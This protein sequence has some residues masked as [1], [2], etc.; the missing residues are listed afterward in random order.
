MSLTF[1]CQ[2]IRADFAHQSPA[3]RLVSRL[4]MK[5]AKPLLEGIKLVALFG[6]V[7]LVVWN[8]PEHEQTSRVGGYGQLAVNR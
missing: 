1:P 2:T 5:I 3:N 8:M 7:A 6:A 4:P